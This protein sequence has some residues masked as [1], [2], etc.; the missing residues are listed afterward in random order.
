MDVPAL[1][2][3]IFL[4]PRKS[5]IDVVQAVGRVMRQAPGKQYGYIILPVA[6]PAGEVPS[7]ALKRNERYRLIW[8]VLQALRAHDTRFNAMINQIELNKTP[9]DQIRVIG[10][11]VPQPRD[12]AGQVGKEESAPDLQAVLPAN[13]DE[14]RDAI[15]AK[16]VD[17]VGSRRYWEDWAKDVADIVAAHTARLTDL[18]NSG[19]WAIRLAFDAFLGA[20][21]ANLND[22]IDQAQAIDMLSQ[23]MVTKPVFDALFDDYQFSDHNPVAQVMQNMLDALEG[24]NLDAETAS[25]DKFYQSV[26]ERVAGVNNAEGKQRVLMELYEKFFKLAFKKTSESL[27]IVYT[28]VE[29]VDFILRGVGHLLQAHFGQSISDEGVHVLDPFTGTGTFIVRL[30]ESGLIRPADL[31]RKYANELHANEILLLAYY[32]ATANIEVTYHG[33]AARQALSDSD[34]STPSQTNTAPSSDAYVP[35]PGIVLADTFQMTE[36]GDTLDEKVF[37]A[38]NHRAAAQLELPIRV[39]VG[40]PPYSVGQS[41]GNDDNQNLK[42]PTLDARIE[43]T[44]AARSTAVN[45][46]SLYDSYIRAIRWASDRVGERGI[47]AYVSNGGY[48]DGNTADGLRQCLVDE[49][50]ALYVYNLRGN[51]RTAGDQRQKEAGNI[52]GSGSRATVAILLAVK[53]PGRNGPTVL[54]YCDIGDY[55]TREQKLAIVGE[56][57]IGSV[58]WESVTPNSAGD[59]INQR[60]DSFTNYP[61]IGDKDDPASAVF[62]LHSRGLATGR[63]AWMYSFSKPKLTR[64]IDDMVA[65]YNTQVRA[66]FAYGAGHRDGPPPRVDLDPTKFSWN[67]ADRSNLI[68]TLYLV[69]PNRVFTAAYRPFCKQLVHFDRQLNDMVYRLPEAFPTAGHRNAGFILTGVSSH[70]EFAAVATNCLPDLHLLDTGQFFPFWTYQPFSSE[71]SQDALALDE[72]QG[73]IVDGYRRVDNITDEALASYRAAY[74]DQVTKEDIFFYVYALLHSPDYRRAFAAD[75]K[76]MLPRIPL[77]D[78]RQSFEA[79]TQAGSQLFHLQIKYE[80]VEPWP[81]LVINGADPAGDPL[82][83]FKVQKMSYGKQRV[84]GKQVADKTTVVYNPHITV[85][86]IPL[87]AQQY[88]L[89][90]RSAV[91]WIIERYQIKTD[92]PSGIVNDPNDWSIEHDQPRY[93]LDL[94][95]RIVTVSVRTVQIVD[96]LPRLE[97]TEQGAVTIW[98]QEETATAQ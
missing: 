55:L 60:D 46:N 48:I 2:A 1:D 42:Y 3:V 73:E 50:S 44:Y 74:G 7:E 92:K 30:L 85:S 35:F 94:L 12:P 34:S 93:I 33:I 15:Y 23:H 10:A 29:I 83:W 67:R 91:D 51:A 38:N 65:F 63:D 70:Y 25:L 22:S 28:P 13:W 5:E 47:V 89:G 19:Q 53:Q 39:V 69:N 66:A 72:P 20:L 36:A 64:R 8:Q 32:I 62:R 80:E 16:I 9:P 87:E 24:Q 86:G 88:M 90:A 61:P 95:C 75:L 76:K 78:T 17:K 54:H 96:A 58:P 27:G 57:T 79:F 49:F 68:N 77:I 41:S 26:R 45:K 40:N 6:I 84:D 18:V 4:N 98:D 52:F 81:D 97:F 82:N 21:R 37:V 59:W 11:D 31:A 14:W 43:A 56:S 71:A